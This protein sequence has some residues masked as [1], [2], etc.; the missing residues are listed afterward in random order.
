MPK[1]A[2]PVM[3]VIL[4]GWGLRSEKEGN[5]IAQATIPNYQSMW[6]T[7]PHTALRSSGEAVGLPLGQMGNSEVG[8]LNIGA[9]RVVYQ[10]LTR[11]TK[12]IKDGPFFDNIELNGLMDKC[13]KNNKAL[14]I[15]GLVSDGGVHSH[16]EHLFAILELAHRKNLTQVFIHAFLDGRDVLPSCAVPFMDV[17]EDRIKELGIGKIASVM[18]RYYPMD[19]DNRW[20]RISRAYKAMVKGEGLY[21]TMAKSA[22]EQSYHKRETDEFVE[23]TVMVDGIGKPVATIEDGDGLLFFNFRADRAREITRAFTDEN[24]QG[25]DREKFPKV[26]FLCMTEYDI[27]IDAPVAFRPQNFHNTLGE[28]VSAADLRQL[29]VAETEKYAHVTFF[30]NGGVEEPYVGEERILVPSPKVATYNL[31]PEMSA[32]ELTDK[33]CAKLKDNIF[34]LIVLNF[35]NPDMVGHTGILDVSIK[36]VEA[37]DNCLGKIFNAI[38]E[39]NGVLMIT[40]D[41]GNSEEMI[42][43]VTHGVQTAHSV[44]PV[45]FILVD[46]EVKGKELRSGGSLQDVAPTIL[47]FLKVQQPVE[48]TGQNL[49]KQ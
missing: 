24:F 41:H 32:Y 45:P 21:A 31:Q 38:K 2:R 35:A 39:V 49:L 28:V 20:E 7:Y 26:N 33:V 18:G 1:V 17:L 10:E 23:P 36:A 34:D 12:A 3:L 47:A 48:M 44:F 14:H 6:D 4:D 29:R 16:I 43:P 13:L 46:D 9:G 40:A 11:I 5:A 19:R 15:M 27:T 22:V 8:H 37:V 30:F 25:F 42:D